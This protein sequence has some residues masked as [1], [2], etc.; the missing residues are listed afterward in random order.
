MDPLYWRFWRYAGPAIALIG[1]C[2]GLRVSATDLGRGHSPFWIVCEGVV[3][4]MLVTSVGV[5]LST[6]AFFAYSLWAQRH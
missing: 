1:I 2:V 5:L 4:A 3:V 6:A